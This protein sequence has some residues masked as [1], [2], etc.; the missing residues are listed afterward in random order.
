MLALLLFGGR[1]RGADNGMGAYVYLK[2]NTDL[3]LGEGVAKLAE[4]DGDSG[5]AL[6]AAKERARADLAA[7]IRVRVRS[8]TSESTRSKDGKVDEEL[9]SRSDSQADVVLENVKYLD[10]RAMPD[11]EHVTVLA[12]L[13][14]EDYRKQLAGKKVSVYLPE[15]GL[16]IG[17]GYTLNDTDV[18][19]KHDQDALVQSGQLLGSNASN[20]GLVSLDDSTVSLNLDYTWNSFVAQLSLPNPFFNLGTLASLNFGYDWTPYAT[21]FQPFVPL[22][23]EDGI[24]FFGGGGNTYDVVGLG[25]GLGLRFWVNDFLALQ[26]IGM[27]HQG[28]VNLQANVQLYEDAPAS[29]HVNLSLDGWE[30]QVGVLLSSF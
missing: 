8:E 1:L 4:F 11:Q 6:A 29:T 19:L 23:L 24:W 27:R 13:S 20:H 10:F 30:W 2:Q 14:K 28:I 18:A 5:K 17:T 12:S 25:A 3:Y 15:R 26:V 9:S 21:R 22:R 7:T 16:R